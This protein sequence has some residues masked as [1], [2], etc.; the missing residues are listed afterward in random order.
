M[1]QTLRM[2]LVAVRENDMQTREAKLPENGVWIVPLSWVWALSDGYCLAP[3]LV[4][5]ISGKPAKFKNTVQYLQGYH[6]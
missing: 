3:L 5:C 6:M 2:G 1:I 4:V